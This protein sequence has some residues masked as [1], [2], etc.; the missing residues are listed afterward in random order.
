MPRG[1]AR[2]GAGRKP[3][4]V[5]KNALT[6]V[7]DRR[8]RE[9]RPAADPKP[10]QVD[11]LMVMRQCL[12]LVYNDVMDHLKTVRDIAVEGKDHKALLEAVLVLKSTIQSCAAIAKDIAP[13]E[14]RR[15]AGEKPLDQDRPAGPPALMLTA[16]E[17][18]Q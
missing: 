8:K 4:S 11:S 3:G 1:G 5:T 18:A 7:I 15:L 14:H 17:I 12:G 2:P 13:F 9:G 16:A 6:K 10:S